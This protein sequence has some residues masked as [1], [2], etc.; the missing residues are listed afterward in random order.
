MSGRV[1]IFLRIHDR[2]SHA[3]GEGSLSSCGQGTFRAQAL[4]VCHPF[5]QR[6]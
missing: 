2:I 1:R 5:T 6:H 4:T 3:E